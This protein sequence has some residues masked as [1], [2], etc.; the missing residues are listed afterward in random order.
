MKRVILMVLMAMAGPI[1]SNIASTAWAAGDQQPREGVDAMIKADEIADLL[2]WASNSKI[3]LE[4]GLK[5]IANLPTA[6]RREALRA[7]IESVVQGSGTKATELLMRVVLNRALSVDDLLKANSQESPEQESLGRRIL[8]DAALEA[9][10]VYVDDSEF[11]NRAQATVKADGGQK[12]IPLDL[13]IASLGISSAEYYARR[14]MAAP[15]H[16]ATLAIL[17]LDL[18]LF[19]NDLNRGSQRRQFAAVLNHIVEFNKTIGSQNPTTPEGFLSLERKIKAF[20]DEQIAQAKKVPLTGGVA[21][22]AGGMNGGTSGPCGRNS[23][24]MG[25]QCIRAGSFMMGSPSTEVGRSNDE[26][27]H[28]VRISRNFEMQV[29]DVTQAQWVA[30][31]GSNPS[32]F[33]EQSHCVDNHQDNPVSM[34]PNHPVDTVSFNDVQDY[35]RKLNETLRDGYTYRLP[36]EAEWEYA[37]RAGT[38]T[39]YYFGDGTS[40]IDQYAWYSG[41]SNSQTHDVAKLKP[42]AFGLYDMSGLVWQWVQDWYGNYSS[43]DQV[44]PLGANTG[45]YRVVR[46]GSWYD[47]AQVLRS[48]SR[49]YYSPGDRFN[50]FGFRLVRTH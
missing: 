12:E 24:G 38:Q 49:G 33:K 17:K 46:G 45:S 8:K 10:R 40:S 23:V 9:L 48:A 6:Q 5:G 28:Q 22:Y 1:M 32:H 16:A 44:D 19:F 15:S 11:L 31:M 42:N 14:G 34:C 47:S 30:V 37:A 25:F 36:T 39:A 21:G 13:P 20:L 26:T 43:Q 35:V 29:T 7:L 50:V 3:Q 18:G 4:D 2:A 27:P 41:N